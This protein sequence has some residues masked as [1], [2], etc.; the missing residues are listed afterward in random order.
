MA[1]YESK[2]S[3]GK[4]YGSQGVVEFLTEAVNNMRKLNEITERTI[5]QVNSYRNNVNTKGSRDPEKEEYLKN[6]IGKLTEIY[7][8]IQ[9]KIHQNREKLENEA[10]E[11]LRKDY[12]VEAVRDVYVPQ[13]TELEEWENQLN[14]RINQ[15]QKLRKQLEELEK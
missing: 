11:L 6:Q 12:G 4:E 2:D 8:T 15:L 7:G 10:K 5:K 9:K 13:I 14:D 3:K 1:T